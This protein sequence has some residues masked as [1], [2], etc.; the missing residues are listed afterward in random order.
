ML[1]NP[2]VRQFTGIWVVVGVAGVAVVAGPSRLGRT[3]RTCRTVLDKSPAV[4]VGW[5]QVISSS[6]SPICRVSRG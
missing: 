4:V 3:C 2:V 6:I 1:V 5:G